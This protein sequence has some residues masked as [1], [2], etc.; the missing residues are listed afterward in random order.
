MVGGAYMVGGACMVA[1][2]MHSFRWACMVGGH[3]WLW[4]VCMVAGGMRGGRGACMGYDKIQSMSRRY[5]S[6]WNAFLLLF[7]AL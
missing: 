1:G 4:G 7:C 3:V 2:G 5:A 6:Y